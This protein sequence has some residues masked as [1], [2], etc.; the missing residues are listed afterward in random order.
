MKWYMKWEL[1][2]ENEN[3]IKKEDWAYS[4]EEV[5][6]HFTSWIAKSS[7]VMKGE[8]VCYWGDNPYGS[9]NPCLYFNVYAEETESEDND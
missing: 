1:E 9:G 8:V 7:D 4:W 5:V 3:H 2:D 6:G